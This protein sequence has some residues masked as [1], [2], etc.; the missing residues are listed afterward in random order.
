MTGTV[1]KDT[2]VLGLGNPLMGDEGIGPAIIERL[3]AQAENFPSIDFVDA[4]TGGLTVLHLISDRK[5]AILIDCAYMQTEPGT[6]RKFTPEEVLSVKELTGRSL[7]EADILSVLDM[8]AEL[9]QCP[10]EVVIFGI[11]PKSIEPRARLSR[12]LNDRIDNY[13]KTVTDELI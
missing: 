9:G 4:G 11:E 6:I 13:V 7:H 8:A 2:V 10:P 3:I 12:T 1:K 5:K